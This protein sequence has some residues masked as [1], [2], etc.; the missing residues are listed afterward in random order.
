MPLDKLYFYLNFPTP[1]FTAAITLTDQIALTIP[2]T[3]TKSSHGGFQLLVNCKR[4]LIQLLP[5][6]MEAQ[7]PKSTLLPEEQATMEETFRCHGY[8]Y[9]SPIGEGGFSTVYLVLS[10]RY[11]CQF[12]IKRTSFKKVPQLITHEVD[13]EI[14]SLMALNHPNIIRF[15]AFFRDPYALYT[16]LEYYPSGSIREQ[17]CPIPLPRFVRVARDL[18]S[19]LDCCHAKK[20][21]HRDIKPANI[22]IDPYGRAILADFGLAHQYKAGQVGKTVMGSRFYMAP[23]L[24]RGP[25]YDPFKADIWSLGATFYFIVTGT[26]PWIKAGNELELRRL[27]DEGNFEYPESLHE[28]VKDLLKSMLQVNATARLSTKELL[29]KVEAISE[30]VEAQYP[31]TISKRRSIGD[32]ERRGV[33]LSRIMSMRVQP[34]LIA[35]GGIQVR[36]PSQLSMRRKLQRAGVRTLPR[37]I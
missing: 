2:P 22:L 32:F 16:V 21:A 3:V 36:L 20:I 24:G 12:C 14:Q 17:E 19:A 5:N 31:S 9:I 11:N 23:E 29:P 28:G 6:G 4:F 25:I 37:D 7:S 34:D 8:E 35:K 27:I 26:L 1:F 13:P 18:L 30:S 15:F 10:R 33:M